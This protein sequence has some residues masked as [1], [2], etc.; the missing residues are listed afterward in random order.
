M[1][2]CGS[3]PAVLCASLCLVL[4]SPVFADQGSS[5]EISTSEPPS[6]TPLPSSSPSRLELL[7][8]L[9]S[10]LESSHILS[11]G[12]LA[13]LEES[14]IILIAPSSS[15]TLSS[16]SSEQWAELTREIRAAL[17][18]CRT[19][20]WILRGV[21]GALVGGIVYLLVRGGNP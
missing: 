15:S 8:Q 14:G 7:L 3:L 2:H 4:S 21:A 11:A 10:E 16:K 19:E 17:R 12:L 13:R 9:R 18:W 6:A 20:V 1:K 5:A